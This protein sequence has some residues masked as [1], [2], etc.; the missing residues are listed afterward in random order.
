VTRWQNVL[1]YRDD[2]VCICRP[3]TLLVRF[4]SVSLAQTLR[5]H[6]CGID[7]DFGSESEKEDGVFEYCHS[8]PVVRS[9]Q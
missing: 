4:F 9:A 7:G 1:A 5:Y 3:S 8:P 6:G 2:L